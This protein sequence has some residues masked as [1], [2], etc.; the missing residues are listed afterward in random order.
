[1]ESL[2]RV[3]LGERCIDSIDFE[4]F[5][6]YYILNGGNKLDKPVAKSLLNFLLSK[7]GIKEEKKAKKR[8]TLKAKSGNSIKHLLSL[9]F[10]HFTLFFFL[11][12]T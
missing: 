5:R 12:S 9:F 1:M 4:G 6:K 3:A 7:T 8:L 10:I 11:F 2:I